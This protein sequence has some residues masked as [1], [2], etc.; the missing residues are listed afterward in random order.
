MTTLN[1]SIVVSGFNNVK[2][3]SKGAAHVIEAGVIKPR[4]FEVIGGNNNRLISLTAD[5]KG[6]R[7]MEAYNKE[8]KRTGYLHSH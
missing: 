8:A 5:D 7:I 1:V 4:N 3:S 2:Q 6:H